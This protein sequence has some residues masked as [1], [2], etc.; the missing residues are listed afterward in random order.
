MLRHASCRDS[1]VPPALEETRVRLCSAL[2]QPCALCS[3]PLYSRDALGHTARRT[4]LTPFR[5]RTCIRRDSLQRA[6]SSLHP[7]A[8]AAAAA[9]AAFHTSRLRAGTASCSIC[10]TT[11]SS[12]TPALAKILEQRRGAP[13]ITTRVSEIR[14]RQD[15][16]E[17][18]QARH[19]R[20][21]RRRL[22]ANLGSPR[23]I[24][25]DLGR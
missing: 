14:P 5:S 6:V 16:Q 9:A 4:A 2:L 8:A 25:G 1:R 3:W 23:A 13:E 20:R 24:S 10:A 18:R 22:A 7:D 11:A 12:T 21:G 19:R 17:A 15:P